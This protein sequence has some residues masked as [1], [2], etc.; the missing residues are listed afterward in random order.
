MTMRSLREGEVRHRAGY[1]SIP[2]A[3]LKRRGDR[4]KNGIGRWRSVGLGR[5][6]ESSAGRK[7][8]RLEVTPS[9]AKSAAGGGEAGARRDAA[10]HGEITWYGVV[11]CHV[12]H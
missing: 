2:L 11:M 10:V 3:Y 8:R 9:R 5:S 12:A 7:G 6:V 1:I 4:F